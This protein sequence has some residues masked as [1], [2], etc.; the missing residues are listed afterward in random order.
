[1]HR[2]RWMLVRMYT[3]SLV[4]LAAAFMTS[5]QIGALGKSRLLAPLGEGLAWIPHALFALGVLSAVITSLRLWAWDTGR[6]PTCA[7]G[8]LLGRERQGRYGPYRKCLAC[9]M[10]ESVRR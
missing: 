5:G 9:G 4:M 6:A 10:N 2:I 1:M 3:P 7:C 8:G